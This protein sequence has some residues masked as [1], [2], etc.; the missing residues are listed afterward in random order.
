MHRLLSLPRTLHRLVHFLGVPDLPALVLAHPT[1][2]G[3]SLA[4]PSISTPLDLFMPSEEDSEE[5]QVD[6]EDADPEA[7]LFLPEPDDQGADQEDADPDAPELLLPLLALDLL[8]SLRHVDVTGT[9]SRLPHDNFYRFCDACLARGISIHNDFLVIALACRIPRNICLS[10]DKLQLDQP[11]LRLACRFNGH[12]YPAVR[13]CCRIPDWRAFAAANPLLFQAGAKPSPQTIIDLSSADV[14]H[15]HLE[16][17]EPTPLMAAVDAN[18]SPEVVAH[19]AENWSRF[20]LKNTTALM[21]AAASG[22]ARLV[23]ALIPFEAGIVTTNWSI[24]SALASAAHAGHVDCVSL[25]MSSEAGLRNRNGWT[26]LMSAAWSG[27]AD[28]V[29]LL[30]PTEAGLKREGG[31]T[32]LAVAVMFGHADCVSLLVQTE[33]GT[34]ANDGRTALMLAAG[35]G[36]TDCVTL[37]ISEAGTAT[38][39]G[40]TA[41]MDAALDGHADCVSLLAPTEARMVRFDG[42][43]ALMLAALEGHTQCVAVLAPVEADCIDNSGCTALMHATQHGHT[44]CAALSVQAH[45]E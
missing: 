12:V 9:A 14:A 5:D 38:A 36:F 16:V 30:V 23:S 10:V 33:A 11:V 1:L 19:L 37:L 43:T 15:S 2:Y 21:R 26:A 29:S 24:S 3:A 32:A 45:P 27:H 34:T 44:D 28:C 35:H 8:P 41:L 13:F 20:T 25:L 42:V 31:W 40:W 22:N 39:N 4:A 18:S 7:P 17:S 6:S